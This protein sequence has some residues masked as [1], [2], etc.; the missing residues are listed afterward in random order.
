MIPIRI[1]SIFSQGK[2]P[3]WHT[4]RFRFAVWVAGLLLAVL[5][6]FSGFVYISMRYSLLKAVDDSLRLN[7][8][9][10]MATSNIEN[11]QFR[12]SDSIPEGSL[13]ED[14][15]SRGLSIRVLSPEGSLLEAFGPYQDLPVS[16]ESI[17]A[18]GARRSI[19]FTQ[20]EP[21]ENDAV[22]FYSVPVIEND[23]ILGI[24]QVAQNLDK[25]QDTLERL[26]AA[27]LL[28]APFV[29]CAAGLG[30]Y[31]LVARALAPIDHMT[32]TARRLSAE[33]LSERLNLP[34]T[35]DEVGR[36]AS[37][38]D[39]M[40]G[41]L[42]AAFRRE[43]QFTSDASHELRTPLAAMQAIIGVV[44]ERRRAPE[45]YEQALDD[46]AEQTDRLR[47]LTEDL[48]NLARGDAAKPVEFEEVDVSTLLCDLSDSFR[49]L[50]EKKDLTLITN[51]PESI[52]ISGDSDSLIRLFANLL[53]NAIKY[54]SRGGI[55]LSAH[56]TV[57]NMLEVFIT[58]TGDGIPAEDLP[59][60]FDRF[61][62]VEKS[63][64]TRGTGLGL[65]IAANIAH[66]H[67]GSIEVSSTVGEGT[68]FTV[69]LPIPSPAVLPN[70]RRV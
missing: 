53:D 31:F 11:G 25:L 28:S 14:L 44:R 5:A 41:R 24:V 43:R 23:R 49:P 27:I 62:R 57:E 12:F 61:Y 20:I 2:T 36:L 64:A 45:D 70:G 8:S 22:R 69:Q 18:A 1:N 47:T 54:T 29:I 26:L 13:E 16:A 68:T 19:F 59:H 55:T 3:F 42:E 39:S 32:R 34:G 67:K 37:T 46:L 56:R 40:L 66:A 63:R 10:A 33:D 7:A 4:L 60:I 48:L 58:D 15:E 21:E 50:A 65:A 6:A 51:L 35:D 30:G 9:Q 17:A 52:T 38:F